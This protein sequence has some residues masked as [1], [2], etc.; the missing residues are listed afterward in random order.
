M[1]SEKEYVESA[2][3]LVN[4]IIYKLDSLND[5]VNKFCFGDTF[6]IEEASFQML[7]K[8]IKQAQLEM[9]TALLISTM[10]H[11]NIENGTVKP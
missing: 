3:H 1:M 8:N 2:I 4:T 9:K 7:L 10:W 11:S 6:H 5:C